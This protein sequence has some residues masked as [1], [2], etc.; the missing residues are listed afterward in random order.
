MQMQL[1]VMACV[2]PCSVRTADTAYVH[3]KSANHGDLLDDKI[4]AEVITAREI[5]QVDLTSWGVLDDTP[6]GVTVDHFTAQGKSHSQ[7]PRR[8]SRPACAADGSSLLATADRAVTAAEEEA[9]A[10][11]RIWVCT[12]GV[13][14]QHVPLSQ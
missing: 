5:A 6:V 11:I 3:G 7:A 12:G 14:V 4:A 1:G 13:W 8:A 2:I 10:P 9:I